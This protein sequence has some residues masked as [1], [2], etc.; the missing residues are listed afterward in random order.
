MGAGQDG[1]TS[2][3]VG[4]KSNADV[5]QRIDGYAAAAVFCSFYDVFSSSGILR[6]VG[7]PGHAVLRGVGESS[8]GMQVVKK[9]FF[10]S[11]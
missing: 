9:S 7:K 2:R 5:L 8:Q 11:L 3:F 6:T 1:F 10:V 4:G